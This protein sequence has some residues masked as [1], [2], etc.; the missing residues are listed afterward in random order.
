MASGYAPLPE[1][2]NPANAMINFE[3]VSQA[4]GDYSK[5]MTLAGESTAKINA[6]NAMAAGDYTKAVG[7]L[8][9]VDPR[10][11]MEVGMYPGKKE[12]QSQKLEKTSRELL[13][14][15]AQTLSEMK[16]PAERAA[17]MTR[18][19]EG[20]PKVQAGLAKMGVDWRSNPDLAIKS[21]YQDALGA[22]DPEQQRL[23]EAQTA[24]AMTEKVGPAESLVRI[25][26]VG[27]AGAPGMAASAAAPAGQTI[28][29]GGTTLQTQEERQAFADRNGIMPGT[30]P[31]KQL[32][33]NGKLP[34]HDLPPREAT[35]VDQN[36][37][38]IQAFD[39]LTQKLEDA[40]KYSGDAFQ[41]AFAQARTSAVQSLPWIMPDAARKAAN[42]T[43]QMGILESG[44]A[45]GQ[46]KTDAGSRVTAYLEQLE[47]KLRASPNMPHET[48]VELMNEAQKFIAQNR[49]LAARQ[50]TAIL[51]R[52]AF[53]PGGGYV[54]PEGPPGAPGG[55]RGGIASEADALNQARAKISRGAKPELV[56]QRLRELG[57]DPGKL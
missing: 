33:V 44:R 55:Q 23:I 13:G 7:E 39:N 36:V 53:K 21:I 25:P 20:S 56:I 27:A 51:N 43:E 57:I 14:A 37:K 30:E 52:T 19:A 28:Y 5:G 2:K 1:Y 6:A 46:A 49:D 22:Q 45:L 41:G 18:W 54:T 29:K 10:A 50:N 9:K 17:A 8:A 31:Y 3:P 4:L 11:A 34:D 35:M 42:A 47:M 12:E 38:S 32:M 48:R 15:H 16:D 26:P 24:K 40:K